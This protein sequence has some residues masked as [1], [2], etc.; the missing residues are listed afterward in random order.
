MMSTKEIRSGNEVTISAED[1]KLIKSFFPSFKRATGIKTNDY[2]I[3]WNSIMSVVEF[4]AEP[5]VKGDQLIRSGVDIT[6]FYKA[7]ELE[8]SPDED[9]EDMEDFTTHTQGETKIE[10]VCKAV[11]AFIEWYNNQKATS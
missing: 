8:F 4:L 11:L 5:V 10:S 6:I 9:F 2:V 1:F 3:D 7:C